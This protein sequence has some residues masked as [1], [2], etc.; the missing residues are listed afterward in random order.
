MTSTIIEN[1]D[2]TIL[3]FFR[4]PQD[5]SDP[6]GPLWLEEMVRD[7][8]AFGSHGVLLAITVIIVGFL[9]LTRKRHA[10]WMILASVGSGM[11]LSSLLKWGIDRARPDIVPHGMAVYTQSF[12]S[13][14]A[15]LSAVVYLTLGAL[16][17]RSQHEPRV[18][19]F[20][21]AVAVML[22]VAVGLSRIYL[23]VHW[24]TDVIAGWIIGAAWAWLCWLVMLRL[25]RRG[26][27]ES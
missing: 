22:A 3:L 7:F 25:Q 1:F 2:R 10:A 27:V 20:L 21:I 12:P 6:V 9:M 16:L 26:K 5:L 8:T 24:P 18:K 4:S 19:I 15:M 23:G 11:L 13:G 17:A 14:H